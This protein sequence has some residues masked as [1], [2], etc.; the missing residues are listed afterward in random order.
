MP[1]TLITSGPR[2]WIIGLGLAIA[3]LPGALHAQVGINT[4]VSPGYALGGDWFY[5]NFDFSA[6]SSQPGH[7]N[8]KTWTSPDNAVVH[9]VDIKLYRSGSGTCREFYTGN[10]DG[11][12]AKLW[13]NVGSASSPVWVPLSTY[14]G[15][16]IARIWLQGLVGDEVT[17]L[18]LASLNSLPANDQ[19]RH[20]IVLD[21]MTPVGMGGTNGMNTV[22]S[23]QYSS[24]GH[25]GGQDYGFL[26]I[27]NGVAQVV[28]TGG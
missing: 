19:G 15:N 16:P 13:A 14:S 3:A 23:C 27:I 22:S 25:I 26:K 2:R 4:R 7:L 9:Y 18:R 24:Y 1:R 28:K 5:Y 8:Y 12:Q 20:S 17:Y 11:A 10:T 21:D 6:A